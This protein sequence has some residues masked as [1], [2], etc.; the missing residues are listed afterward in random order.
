M[1]KDIADVLGIVE[2]TDFPTG[3]KI[4]DGQTFVSAELY[5]DMIQT[6]QKIMYSKRVFPNGNFDN[7]VNGYQMLDALKQYIDEDIVVPRTG[8][9]GR[10]T[11]PFSLWDMST[12]LDFSINYSEGFKSLITAYGVVSISAVVRRP[13]DNSFF[14]INHHQNKA[15]ASASPDEAGFVALNSTT[16]RIEM[17][18]RSG[19]FFNDA[20]FSSASGWVVVEYIKPIFV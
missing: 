8:A 15:T 4:V 9:I 12:T 17:G 3:Y 20:A 13:S 6:F 19:G 2:D 11:I 16:N 10:S 18:I 5:Q 7:E 1:A 14:C